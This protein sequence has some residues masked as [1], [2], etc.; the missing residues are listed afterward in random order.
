[1]RVLVHAGFH[2]TGTTSLQT[3]L[4]RNRAALAPVFDYFG[5]G[6]LNNAGRL[7]HRYA[8]RPFPWRLRRFRRSL[9]TFLA[10]VPLPASGLM[11]ISRENFAG[12]M[13]GHRGLR[14]RP[15]RD[16]ASAATPL[17]QAIVTELRH[18]FGADVEVEFLYTTRMRES[19]LTSVHGHLLR[20]IDLTD[21]FAT[22]R[23]GFAGLVSLDDQAAQI[24]RA[25]APVPVHTAALEDLGH[26]PHGPAT[27]LLDLA[28]VPPDLRAMLSPPPPPANTG[29]PADL[30]AA[31]LALNRQGLPRHRLRSEKEVLLAGT[32]PPAPL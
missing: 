27:A 17:A 11:V 24:A 8:Q 30:R 5:P 23:A 13:P 22:F 28:R 18:R 21:D 3:F 10:G 29:Q 4:A 20:S 6:D 31:F 7:S 14:G 15:L 16:F 26:Q 2:K 25:L 1:M 32:N 9:R 12:L 19:W